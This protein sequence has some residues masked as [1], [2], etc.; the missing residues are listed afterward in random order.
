MSRTSAPQTPR[1]EPGQGTGR[2]A[3]RRGP[4]RHVLL[5][6]AVVL[7]MVGAGCGSRPETGFLTPVANIAPDATRHTILV[8][9]TRKRDD[10]PGTLFGGER[11]K[12][13]DYAKLE[14]SVPKDHKPGD[15]EWASTPP[16]N[17]ATD[18]VV[19][20]ASYLD[21]EKDFVR[22]LNAQLA[23]RKPG[24]R[25]VLVFIHGYNTMFAEGLYRF[26]QIVHD[27]HSPAVPVLFTWASRGQLSQYVYDNN[28]ATAA[29]DELERT[30][31]LIFASNV[32]QVNIL[33][34]SMGNWVTV[35][36]LR[37]IRISDRLPDIRK[38]GSIVLAAPDIDVDVFKSQMRRFG[39]PRKPFYVVLSQDDQA[40]R[41]SR[42]IAG[43]QERLGAGTNTAELTELG[44][45]VID[46]TDVDAIDA[47]NHA[48]FAQ[49]AEIAPQLS[50]VLRRGIS[51][52]P[53][54]DALSNTVE[55]GI[56]VP[57]SILGAP[58]RIITGR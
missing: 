19:S 12:P 44:A 48:K 15:V 28:S 25:K 8:A 32:D 2:P 5:A 52:T 10:R 22:S 53:A 35:E 58:V 1:D 17:P 34:H 46:L 49:L 42:F 9:T 47:S 31:R 30:L 21:G 45:V 36:A 20:Q 33:A 18:F 26:A 38:L 41:A 29:R 16:G 23:T 13:L 56:A 27:S 37:Q 40:L 14:V 57:L 11:G 6:L 43:G 55:A 39:K 51:P 7:T 54:R 50:S 3:L 24:N 4:G